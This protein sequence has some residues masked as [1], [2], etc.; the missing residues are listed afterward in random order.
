MMPLV[1]L[2]IETTGVSGLGLTLT[3]GWSFG[4]AGTLASKRLGFSGVITIKI[5]KR[6][7]NTSIRGVTLMCGEAPSEL[8]PADIPISLSFPKYQRKF[9]LNQNYLA[10]AS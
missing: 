2:V 9:G 1:S 5:I 3:C 4:S 6:T 8:P 7:N 10:G